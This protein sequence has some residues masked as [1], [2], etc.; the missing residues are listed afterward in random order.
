MFRGPERLQEKT[1][2]S[3]ILELFSPERA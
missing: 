2:L 1:A 3:E